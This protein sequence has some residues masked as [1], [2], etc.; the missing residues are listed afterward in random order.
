MQ[1]ADQVVVVEVS[2]L[3]FAVGS[4]AI[5]AVVVKGIVHR[6][7]SHQ[8]LRLVRFALVAAARPI[9]GF[10]SM[11]QKRLL[12]ALDRGKLLVELR[13]RELGVHNHQMVLA[14]RIHL[15]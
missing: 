3:H 7:G 4:A 13:I 14:I 1:I 6:S 12:D 5:V 11:H 2:A 10:L 15:K 9:L 8:S